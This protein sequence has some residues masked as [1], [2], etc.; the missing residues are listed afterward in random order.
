MP[1]TRFDNISVNEERVLVLSIP[2]NA[3]RSYIDKAV[4]GIISRTIKSEQTG[5]QQRD[6]SRSTAKYPFN[7]FPIVSSVKEALLMYDAKR[8]AEEQGKKITNLELASVAGIAV[9]SKNDD[10]K[11]STEVLDSAFRAR[12]LQNKVTRKLKEAKDM[13]EGAAIGQFPK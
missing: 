11:T 6:V 1:Y 7:A 8:H 3:K 10:E 13:V 12:S 4:G 9:K 5:R 2:L